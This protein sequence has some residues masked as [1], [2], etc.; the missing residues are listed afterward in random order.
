MAEQRMPDETTKFSTMDMET[1][2]IYINIVPFV[3]DFFF[4]RAFLF[5]YSFVTTVPLIV[6]KLFYKDQQARRDDSY[7]LNIKCPS[8]VFMLFS[9][10]PTNGDADMCLVIQE[11]GPIVSKFPSQLP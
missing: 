7:C 6:K 5:C 3:S 8:K 11:M 10:L 9:Q 2:L 1:I 4:P